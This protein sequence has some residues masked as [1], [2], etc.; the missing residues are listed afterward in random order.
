MTD[1]ARQLAQTIRAE[2]AYIRKTAPELSWRKKLLDFA[3]VGEGIARDIYK[4]LTAPSTRSQAT[5][6]D[7]KAVARIGPLFLEA[8]A[9]GEAYNGMTAEWQVG[10]THPLQGAHF[11]GGDTPTVGYLLVSGNPTSD[12]DGVVE[13]TS[14]GGVGAGQYR[15]SSDGGSTWTT[16]TTIPSSFTHAGVTVEFAD[17]IVVPEVEPITASYVDGATASWPSRGFDTL[18]LTLGN[19]VETYQSVRPGATWFVEGGGKSKLVGAAS[20]SIETRPSPTTATFA[21]GSSLTVE[22]ET[23]PIDALPDAV[24]RGTE[25]RRRW[26][27]EISDHVVTRTATQPAGI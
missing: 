9:A 18:V 17:E 14:S 13:I 8:I 25:W 27:L 24:A 10:A 21:G 4:A 7:A 22:S 5:G 23:D 20:W 3:A 16:P 6:T 19:I 1:S 26:V 11:T 12:F 15:F 2:V